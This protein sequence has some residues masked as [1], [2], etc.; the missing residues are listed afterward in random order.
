MVYSPNRS[1]DLFL[2]LGCMISNFLYLAYSSSLRRTD[3]VVFAKLNKPPSQV[4]LLSLLT[5]PPPSNVFELNK[6]P[7]A[8]I[9]D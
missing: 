4:S 2:I 3:T 9:E 7:G 5:P 1:L 8:V 6:P